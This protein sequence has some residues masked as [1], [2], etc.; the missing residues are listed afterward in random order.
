M[1]KGSRA[2]QAAE[3]GRIRDE[4]ERNIPRRLK[5]DIHLMDLAARIN[6]CPFKT[7]ALVEFFGSL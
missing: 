6:P 1:K 4:F 3:N 7:W 5:P 2:E